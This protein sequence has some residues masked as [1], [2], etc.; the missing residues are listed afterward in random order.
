MSC[1]AARVV[2]YVIW[3][4]CM[5]DAFRYWDTATSNRVPFLRQ[6]IEFCSQKITPPFL[7][8][9]CLRACN[10]GMHDVQIERLLW[11]NSVN[12][13]DSR[14]A[15]K[16]CHGNKSHGL[17]TLCFSAFLSGRPAIY[18]Q[19][20]RLWIR[21]LIRKLW[22]VKTRGHDNI[23]LSSFLIYGKYKFMTS[24]PP[25]NLMYSYGDG[26][27]LLLGERKKHINYTYYEANSNKSLNQNP[28]ENY[29]S[30][31]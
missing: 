7:W 30:T 25:H 6:S 15:G 20:Y 18:S 22:S 31:L 19:E 12:D 17:K 21:Q 3:Q 11:I 9:W 23:K 24:F 8:F 14:K 16:W 10:M 28:Y 29:Y 26:Q 13:V 5:N 4:A 2:N 27:C 1:R